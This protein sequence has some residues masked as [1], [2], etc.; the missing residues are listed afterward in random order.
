VVPLGRY[1]RFN[2]VGA[3]GF[4]L[5]LACVAALTA[6]A[7]APAVVAT[8]VAVEAAVL[9]NFFW[10]ERWTWRDRRAR[11]AER[12]VRLARF[13]LANG[14]V[15]MAGNLAVVWLLTRWGWDVVSSN[16][17]AVL[18]CSVVNFAAGDLL[19]FL[20]AASPAGGT[21]TLETGAETM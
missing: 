8:A 17:A 4:A 5:Q 12:I 2:A 21:P 1:L 3:A 10:H 7:G 9:H 18:V 16:V 20:P 15:S 11:G 6:W 14:A 13:H 19:V